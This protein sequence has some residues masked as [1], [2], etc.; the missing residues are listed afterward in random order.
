MNFAFSRELELEMYAIEDRFQKSL[1][2]WW[3]DLGDLLGSLQS[4][5]SFE[6]IPAVT[7]LAYKYL[8]MDNEL[9]LAMANLF[10]TLYF[11]NRI[12]TLVRDSEEGQLHNQDMQ[13]TIL[14][15]DYI[16][17]RV[18]KLL[19]EAGADQL[20]DDFADMISQI[21]EGSVIKHKLNENMQEVLRQT[22]APFYATAFVT[23]AKMKG[24]NGVELK[25]YE[26]LGFN[27]GMALELIMSGHR[28]EALSYIEQTHA[29]MNRFKALTGNLNTSLDKLVQELL[30]VVPCYDSAAVV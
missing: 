3:D 30:A 11:A 10:K 14:I 1:Q 2:P 7:V 5:R 26:E 22:S 9:R 12:H 4:D 16:F 13:F 18:L 17:G 29:S 25:L 19:L 8:D 24:L 6:I 15:G 20:L 23:A 28:R 21:N 27:L